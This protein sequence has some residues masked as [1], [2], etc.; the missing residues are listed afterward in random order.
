MG[1]K[2]EELGILHERAPLGPEVPEN[3]RAH[4]VEEELLGHT[5]EET[6]RLLQPAEQAE[7]VLSGEELEPQEA[8][9]AQDHQEGIADP[10]GKAESS[11]VHL[12]LAPGRRFEPDHRIGLH[13]GPELLQVVPQLGD[14]PRVSLGPDLPKEPCPH[15]PRKS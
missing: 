2:A 9:V 1:G 3:D 12:P 7:E 4:R 10:P 15:L 8:G 6:E 11:D 5:A 13:P 14:P